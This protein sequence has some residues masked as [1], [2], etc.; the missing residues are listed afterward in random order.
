MVIEDRIITVRKDVEIRWKY[1][2]QNNC[3]INLTFEVPS[4]VV[5]LLSFIPRKNPQTC[6][7][8]SSMTLE[9]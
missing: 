4:Y 8:E 9:T 6:I 7:F 2:G 5:Q 1:S 3:W